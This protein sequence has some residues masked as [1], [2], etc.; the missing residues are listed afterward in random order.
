[1]IEVIDSGKRSAAEHMHLDTMLLSQIEQPTLRFYQWEQ[2]AITYGHF[3]NPDE[4]LRSLES[5][6]ARRPTGGGLIFHDEDFAFTLALPLSHPLVALPVL[7]RYHSINRALLQAITAFMPHLDV[8]LHSEEF[9]RGSLSEL[10]MAHPTKYD[11]L[12]KQK[13]VGGA[14]QRK[15]R[16]GFIHQC[17]LILKEPDWEKIARELKEP[18]RIL[19]TLKAT[20]CGLFKKTAEKRFGEA[21][22]EALASFII[23]IL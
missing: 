16:S 3:I 22:K 5:D 18:E 20:T 4:W 9:G 12:I 15:T 17:S 7:E 2:F 8:T 13:K 10:C 1:M 19:P 23:K 21:L 11:L 6:S 14:A